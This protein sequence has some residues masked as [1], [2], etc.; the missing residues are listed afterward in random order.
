MST[1]QTT[2]RNE[3][4][5]KQR[6]DTGDM[7]KPGPSGITRDATALFC[8]E[9]EEKLPESTSGTN[10]QQARKQATLAVLGE[11]YRKDVAY[12]KNMFPNIDEAYLID[13]RQSNITLQD[14]VEEI[15]G[16]GDSNGFEG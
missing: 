14:A 4:N 9:T 11:E 10:Q 5:E 1:Q 6:K 12:L 16:E 3:R 7:S 15:L 13:K 2:T 8:L